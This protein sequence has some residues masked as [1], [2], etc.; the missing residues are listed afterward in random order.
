VDATAAGDTFNA[1]LAIALAEGAPIQ[2]VL[3]FANAA[4]AVSVT[5]SGA[6][7]S[8]PTRREADRL[9]SSEAQAGDPVPHH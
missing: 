8:A 2:H 6:Q 4:A 9:L 5:R 7:A 1:G 3:R